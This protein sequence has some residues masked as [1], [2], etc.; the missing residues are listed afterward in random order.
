MTTASTTP[1]V[2]IVTGGADGFGAAICD[3][4]SQE[5]WKVLI[6][7]LN[8]QK[9]EEKTRQDGN[10]R[11]MFG[12]VASR[13]T[14]E[15]ALQSVQAEFGRVDL[16]V[17]NA[18]IT[19]NPTPTHL[20]DIAEYEKTFRVN[21]LPIFLSTQVIAPAMMEQ[22]NGAFVNI[23]STGCT[24]PRPGFAFYNSSKAAVSVA[25]KTM[26]L[27]YAPKIRFNCVAPAVGQTSMLQ[28]SI[29]QGADS[30]ER[31][32]KIEESLPMRRVTQPSDIAN[33]VWYLGTDQS[34]F[35]TGTT[36]EVDGGRGV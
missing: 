2:A 10:L 1:R 11:Y 13:A 26:A 7:D 31:L 22:G 6:L 32:R 27:E 24:R 5:G 3:R 9:G 16:V 12:D 18:G 36:L 25:T 35:V 34:S 19:G 21:V 29:G 4:F 28:A 14:W 30:Q 33:A 23:T 20:K 15:Q 8:Q 17:N